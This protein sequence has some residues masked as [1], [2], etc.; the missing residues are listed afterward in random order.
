MQPRERMHRYTNQNEKFWTKLEFMTENEPWH[1]ICCKRI[2]KKILY[3]WGKKNCVDIFK[4]DPKYPKMVVLP[5]T[6]N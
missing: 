5:E 1:N 6:I 3:F 4:P 2:V